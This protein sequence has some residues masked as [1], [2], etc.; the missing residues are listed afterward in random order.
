MELPSAKKSKLK[1]SAPPKKQKLLPTIEVILKKNKIKRKTIGLNF[2]ETTVS[3]KKAYQK[4]F[5]KSKYNNL[6]KELAELRETKTK[7]EIKTIKRGC[8]ISDQ[9]LKACLKTFKTFKTEAEVKAFL[10]YEAKKK[11]C[12]LA[13]PTIVASGKNSKEVH[14]LTASSK[15]KKGFCIID[16][17]LKYKNYCTD[18]SRT[19][20][21]GKPTKKEI[22]IYNLLLQTQEDAIN[23]INDNKTAKQIVNQVNKELGKYAKNFTHGLGHGFGIQIHELPNLKPDSNDTLKENSVV[24]V[25]PGIYFKNFG[26]RIEDDVLITKKG[27]TTLTKAPKKLITI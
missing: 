6:A 21:L 2:N 18:T 5:K 19:V 4:V 12:D 23:N 9:I 17:G 1:V 3:L 27:A 20:Y 8:K 24:T 7:E 25:E 15:L 10:E 16:F 14:Y 13:F 22:E 11:G 26:I